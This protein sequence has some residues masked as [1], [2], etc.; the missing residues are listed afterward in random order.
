LQ[1]RFESL[2]SAA[3]GKINTAG[4]KLFVKGD[5]VAFMRSGKKLFLRSL[6]VTAPY[7][8]LPPP[9]C[10]AFAADKGKKIEIGKG[11]KFVFE[12]SSDVRVSPQ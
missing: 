3:Y 6:F 11:D 4:G 1:L 5:S 8:P 12:F 2:N 7:R 10:N 9:D